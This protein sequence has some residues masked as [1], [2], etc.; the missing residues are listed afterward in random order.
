M[1]V[2]GTSRCTP[3]ALFVYF[4]SSHLSVPWIVYALETGGMH[5]ASHT[6]SRRTRRDSTMPAW[7]NCKGKAGPH[8]YAAARVMPAIL[9]LCSM[10]L[11]AF[12]LSS[13]P[14]SPMASFSQA[15]AATTPAAAAPAPRRPPPCSVAGPD[16]R[17]PQLRPHC[18]PSRRLQ[19][20][21]AHPPPP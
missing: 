13:L 12:L 16:L 21:R 9:H 17:L 5:D 14:P 7:S 20:P 4:R 11:R 1:T 19:Q 8:I 2:G 6:R 15:D 10:N 3:D 18:P